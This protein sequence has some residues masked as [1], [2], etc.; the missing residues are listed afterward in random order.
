MIWI[1]AFISTAVLNVMQGLA[2]SVVFALLTTV[3]RVQWP[4]YR[5]L[6]RLSGTEEYRDVSHFQELT[7]NF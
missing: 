7:N 5:M 3:F 4:R 2:V 6:S 1:V